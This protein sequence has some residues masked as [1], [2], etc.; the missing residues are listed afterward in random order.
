MP[1]YRCL[2]S[3]AA[4]LP[5]GNLYRFREKDPFGIKNEELRARIKASL[6]DNK[7]AETGGDSISLPHLLEAARLNRHVK[8]HLQLVTADTLVMHS[9]DD[10]T[11]SPR[12]AEYVM[13]HIAS[14]WKEA[15]YLSDC[16]HIITVD[17]EREMV[18]YEV[19]RFIKESINRKLG[20]PVFDL[21][22]TVTR[23]LQRL[24]RRSPRIAA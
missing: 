3:V 22:K 24:E 8:K 16:Y 10:E 17:N 20:S 18:F 9:I 13:E 1:W 6:R 11:A 14:P 21:P 15:I 7:V 12:N 2:L 19:E 5:L 4:I 23:S